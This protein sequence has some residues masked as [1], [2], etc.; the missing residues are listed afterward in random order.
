LLLSLL[1]L[2][3]KAPPPLLL[4]YHLPQEALAFGRRVSC[5]LNLVALRQATLLVLNPC[6]SCVIP[7]L[8]SLFISQVCLYMQICNERPAYNDGRRAFPTCG[9]TCARELE[10]QKMTPS[11]RKSNHSYLSGGSNG[12]HRPTTNPYQT[13]QTTTRM[14]D[15]RWFLTISLFKIS[16]PYL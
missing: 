9:N 8:P 2:R 6:V 4:G 1:R 13:R 7:E 16:D 10:A 5:H 15:V 11:T 14:C 12:P 3:Q